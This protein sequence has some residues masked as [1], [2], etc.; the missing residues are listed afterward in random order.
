MNLLDG[1]LAMSVENTA[2]AIAVAVGYQRLYEQAAA[3]RDTLLK[4]E[5]EP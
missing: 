1:L 3:E 4:T 2:R 5:E